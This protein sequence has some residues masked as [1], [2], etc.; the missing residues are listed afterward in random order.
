[1]TATMAETALLALYRESAATYRQRVAIKAGVRDD[2]STVFSHNQRDERFIELWQDRKA[3]R[4]DARA[5]VPKVNCGGCGRPFSP[6]R[7]NQRFC[8]SACADLHRLRS[9]RKPA[10]EARRPLRPLDNTYG[11]DAAGRARLAQRRGS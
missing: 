7:K 1:M 10:A 11:R 8:T 2:R 4:D 3:R 6:P 5:L 9:R